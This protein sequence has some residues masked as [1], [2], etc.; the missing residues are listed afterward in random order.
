MRRGRRDDRGSLILKLALLILLMLWIIGSYRMKVEAEN[1]DVFVEPV[2]LRCTCYC[3]DGVTASGCKTR[4]G[5][6]ASKKE[7]LGYVACVNAVN[8]DGSI[9][10]FIGFFEILD[11]GYGRETGMG[12]SQ[13]LKGR[14]LGTIETGE[15]VDIYMPTTHQAEEWIDTYGDYVYVQFIKGEG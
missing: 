9:G 8:E 3:D 14:T 5:I 7:Y 4:P 2:K 11:T 15:T 1:S 6:M 10:E 13:I 12:I